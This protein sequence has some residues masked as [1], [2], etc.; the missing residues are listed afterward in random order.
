[1]LIDLS[2]E[3]HA[4]GFNPLDASSGRRRDKAISDLLKTLA[5]IWAS[6]W[7]SRMENA[8]E[9]AL[10]TLFE[11]NRFHVDHDHASQQYTLLD[12][13]MLLTDEHFCHSL[14]DLIDDPFI[15]RWWHLYYDPLN[16]QMQRERSDPVLSKV[17]KFESQLARRIVGQ[18]MSTINFTA[19]YPGGKDYLGE[20]CQ[21]RDW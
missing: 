15:L 8:F 18:A 1:M 20:A 10:R 19:V 11:A 2:D 17:A 7:G 13:M 6:S 9:Y 4:I 21:G 14:L 12:V 3:E 16:P 5:H